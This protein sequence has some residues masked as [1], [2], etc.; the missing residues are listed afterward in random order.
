MNPYTVTTYFGK[1]EIAK[2]SLTNLGICI[3]VEDRVKK[4]KYLIR[5]VIDAEGKW[6]A[7]E[8]LNLVDV[9]VEANPERDGEKIIVS[10]ELLVKLLKE[11]TLEDIL[12]NK[13]KLTRG[14]DFRVNTTGGEAD[15]IKPYR[16]LK[17]HIKFDVLDTVSGKVIANTFATFCQAGLIAALDK[18]ILHVRDSERDFL[19]RITAGIAVIEFTVDDLKNKK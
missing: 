12:Q 19:F 10:S 18:F 5:K 13:V 9:Y 1:G 2:L 4:F 6:T 11:H 14:K 17:N 8:D 7:R 3:D 15:V 16:K